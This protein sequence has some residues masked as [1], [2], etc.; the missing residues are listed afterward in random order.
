MTPT[1][2]YTATCWR[3]GSSWVVHIPELD[4]TSRTGRLSQVEGVARDMVTRVG[5]EHAGSARVVVNL[6]VHDGLMN[7]LDAA[8]AAREDRDRV[9]VEAVTLRRGL[10]RR[11]AGEGFPS[12]MWRPCLGCPSCAPSS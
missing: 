4:R 1:N 12:G 9:S 6:D 3:E 7:L 11:L 2:T 10:A 5:G 8:A